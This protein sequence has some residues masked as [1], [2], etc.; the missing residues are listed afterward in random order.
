MCGVDK[1]SG[2]EVDRGLEVGTRLEVDRVLE[3]CCDDNT[4]VY[5]VTIEGNE[6]KKKKTVLHSDSSDP[7]QYQGLSIPY[8]FIHQC[9]LN[10]FCFM[11]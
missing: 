7:L 5:T 2:L 10:C 8:L 3:V 4:A 1:T 9:L 6:S 11:T